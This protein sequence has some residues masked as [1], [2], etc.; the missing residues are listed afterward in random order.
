MSD[1]ASC[2]TVNAEVTSLPASDYYATLAVPLDATAAAIKAAYRRRSRELHPDRNR[3]PDA[4]RQM[5]ALNS[6]YAVLNNAAAR[7]AYDLSRPRPAAMPV[8]PHPAA[9][10]PREGRGTPQPERFPDWYEFLELRMD[11]NSA[12]VIAALN[13]IGPDLDR[14]GF[15]AADLGVLRLNLKRAAETLT[16]PRVRAVYDAALLGQPPPPGQYA[17]LH[18]DWYSFLGV[19]PT[20]AVDRIAE[21]VTALSAR[22]NRRSP[23]Y[24]EIEAA[25]RTLRDPELRWAYDLG[26]RTED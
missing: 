4:N 7:Q 6:A 16:N 14:G 17:Y 12:E 25:W 9:P 18:H 19:R 11:A 22:T 8:S 10:L 21:Q 1:R 24:R 13:A 15:R 3:S 26:L 20:A 2:G 5:A 23:E